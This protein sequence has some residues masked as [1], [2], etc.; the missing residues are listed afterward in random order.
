MTTK[1]L[2]KIDH[3]PELVDELIPISKLD[4][5]MIVEGQKLHFSQNK[6]VTECL[7]WKLYDIILRVD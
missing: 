5:A 7:K 6:H 2:N 3:L 4:G 1:N